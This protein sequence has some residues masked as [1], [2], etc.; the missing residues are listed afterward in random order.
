M[1]L[2]Q[3]IDLVSEAV[4]EKVG[5]LL[6][7]LSQFVTGIIIGF[8]RGPLLALVISACIPALAIAAAT[9][10]FLLQSVERTK[11]DVYS[12]GDGVAREVLA[13]IRTVMAFTAEPRTYD[14]YARA[15]TRT[16]KLIIR[17]QFINGF[18]MGLVFFVLFSM[19]A[20]RLSCCSDLFIR[21]RVGETKQ[22]VLSIHPTF[23]PHSRMDRVLTCAGALRDT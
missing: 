20:V 21:V 15:L 3:D 10:A 22:I 23:C 9:M 17:S 16:K 6:E 19:Y 4:G 18:G 11:K 1:R 12:Q 8:I 14:K 2:T 7:N 13:A 5:Q